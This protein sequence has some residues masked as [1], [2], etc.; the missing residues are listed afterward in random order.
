MSLRVYS[1]TNGD[2]RCVQWRI[3]AD[4]NLER[5]SWPAYFNPSDALDVAAVKGWRVVASNITNRAEG[6]AAFSRSSTN[7][8]NVVIRANN[9][10][11]KGSNVEIK[12]SVSGRN[13]L[14]FPTGSASEVCGPA[15]PDPSTSA[16]GRVPSY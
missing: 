3:T 11:T 1:Q 6:V 16:A 8:V 15:V 2:P 10:A 5:R 13:T 9:D 12:Q 4:G 14:H 7:I